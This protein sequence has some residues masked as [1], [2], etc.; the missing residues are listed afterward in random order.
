MTP[1]QNAG[2]RVFALV[3]L[4]AGMPPALAWFPCNGTPGEYII[5]R[6]PGGGGI[7][8][9]YLCEVAAPEPAA[10]QEQPLPPPAP[11]S[12]AAFARDE[13]QPEISYT[14]WG[15][16]S[17]IEVRD[18]AFKGC[19]QEGGKDCRVLLVVEPNEWCMLALDGENK[20]F[21]GKAELTPGTPDSRLYETNARAIYNA[22]S[23]CVRES[24]VGMCR[25]GEDRLGPNTGWVKS[26]YVSIETVEFALQLTGNDAMLKQIKTL[27]AKTRAVIGDDYIFSSLMNT[28]LD[29]R[30]YWGAVARDGNNGGVVFAYNQTSEQAAKT[31]ALQGCQRSGCKIAQTFDN[32]CLGVAWPD[33]QGQAGLEL[34]RDAA[35]P[36]TAKAAALAQCS[37]KYGACTAA[38]RCSGSKYPKADPEGRKPGQ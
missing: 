38:V 2:R 37:A 27:D 11:P 9:T 14:V 28:V 4:M 12:Y 33:G 10:P 18:A 32:T 36:T 16:P 22:F 24:R 7:A 1:I 29:T 25:L 31:V 26:K 3:L 30:A 17:L 13:K 23:Q 15:V 8:A 21:P 6:T 34:A 19:Q 5:G 35:S 20:L